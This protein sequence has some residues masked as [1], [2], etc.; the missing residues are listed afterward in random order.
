MVFLNTTCKRF[1]C[2]LFFLMRLGTGATSTQQNPL[3]QGG[4]EFPPDPASSVCDSG[5][6][7]RVVVAA[8]STGCKNDVTHTVFNL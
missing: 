3:N 2:S 8:L 5:I 1:D 7:V 4:I 6:T